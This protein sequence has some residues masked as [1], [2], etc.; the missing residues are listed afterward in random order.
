MTETVDYYL[1]RI[2]PWHAGRPRFRSTVEN[3]VAPLVGLQEFLAHLPQD[4]DLDDAI[5]VQL[6][7]V[8]ERVGR[9]RFIPVP[10]PDYYFSFDDEA[11]GFDKGIWIGPYDSASEANRLDDNTYRRLLYAKI[12]AN[13]WDGTVVGAQAVF[14][15]FFTA[16]ETLILVQDNFDMSMTVG[17]SGKVPSSLFLAIFA[18]NYLP[19]KPE[20]VKSYYAI[21]SIDEQALFGFDMDNQYVRGFDDAAWGVDADYLILHGAPRVGSLDYTDPD[22][23]EFFPG[24]NV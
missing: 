8:G 2:T 17:L 21:T 13:S 22:N 9:S 3:A 16:P 15:R 5:G 4:F 19:M 14:D 7:A 23:I 11:R 20:G 24:L 10:I 18:G 12:M 1:D 6:D